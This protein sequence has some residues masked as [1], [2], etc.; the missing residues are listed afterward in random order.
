MI[1][2]TQIK[3]RDITKIHSDV[4]KKRHANAFQNTAD[5]FHG[6]D[7]YVFCCTFR[8]QY[9]FLKCVEPSRMHSIRE[10]KEEAFILNVKWK[11]PALHEGNKLRC[12]GCS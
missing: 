11:A 9:N 3:T 12:S 5:L 6:C 8:L 4:K 7:N 10:E 2:F 1:H